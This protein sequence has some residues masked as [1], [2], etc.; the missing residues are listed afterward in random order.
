M[1]KW[2]VSFEDDEVYIVDGYDQMIACASYLVDKY[3][4]K[5]GA[6][7]RANMVRCK[8]VSDEE[9]TNWPVENT[10]ASI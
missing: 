10:V 4:E 5:Y 3:K 2:R 1:T 7:F 9:K 6:A 8:T